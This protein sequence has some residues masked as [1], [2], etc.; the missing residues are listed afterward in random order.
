MRLRYGS[1][2]GHVARWANLGRGS[3]AR[4][5]MWRFGGPK[6][7][8]AGLMGSLPGQAEGDESI[9]RRSMGGRVSQAGDTGIPAPGSTPMAELKVACMGSRC[10]WVHQSGSRGAERL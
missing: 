9:R 8:L 5:S 3:R 1:E 6:G 10:P 7:P 4:G 2:A